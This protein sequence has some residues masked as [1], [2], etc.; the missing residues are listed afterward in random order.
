MVPANGE[1]RV[2][3]SHSLRGLCG[4]K[5]PSFPG[6][7]RSC[8]SQPARAVWIEINSSVSMLVVSPRHSLR[9]LCGLKCPLLQRAGL[10]LL[11]HSLRGLCGLKFVLLCFQQGRNNSHSLRGLCGLK[12]IIVYQSEILTASQPARAVWIE[13]AAGTG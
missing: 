9:G 8:W 1:H 5:S 4:L 6:S 10:A 3:L 7:T 12:C 13:I 2:T 11:S